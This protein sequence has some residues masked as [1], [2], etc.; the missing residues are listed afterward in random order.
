MKEGLTK[1]IIIIVS[2][3]SAVV[4]TFVILAFATGNTYYPS[5]SNPDEIFIKD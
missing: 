1:K 5:L 4:L 3:V 2:V